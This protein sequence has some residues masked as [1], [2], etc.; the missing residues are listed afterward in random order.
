MKLPLT[1]PRLTDPCSPVRFRASVAP[2]ARAVPVGLAV[3]AFALALPFSTAQAATFAAVTGLSGGAV[4]LIAADR[5]ASNPTVAVAVQGV[6]LFTGA[7]GA[8]SSGSTVAWTAS[9]AT[10]CYST[11]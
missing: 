2:S 8:A 7:A 3:L 6:G 1:L 9:V 11:A 10:R 5:N 4:S